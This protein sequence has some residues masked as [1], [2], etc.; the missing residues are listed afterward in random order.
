MSL[1]SLF[2]I[3]VQVY[4]SFYSEPA[5][6][7]RFVR[8]FFLLILLSVQGLTTSSELT[9]V[10]LH[11]CKEVCLVIPPVFTRNVYSDC[12]IAYPDTLPTKPSRHLGKELVTVSFTICRR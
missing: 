3:Y 11:M 7:F 1:F 6:T 10:S 12:V 4:E 5:A 9:I 8:F 2:N